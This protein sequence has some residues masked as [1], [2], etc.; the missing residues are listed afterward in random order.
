MNWVRV[1]GDERITYAAQVWSMY[2]TSYAAIGLIAS[3]PD[4]LLTEYD[5]W[6]LAFDEAGLS[7]AFRVAK[8]TPF[9][10]KIGLSGTDG[11]REAKT[12]LKSTLA[13]WFTEPGVYSEVSHK[14]EELARQNRAPAVCTS[15]A[16]RVLRKSI[17]P[18]DAVRYTRNIGP[19]GA[20]TKV[21]VGRPMDIPVVDLDSPS[22]PK[23]SLRLS[24]F[25]RAAASDDVDLLETLD[26]LAPW[27]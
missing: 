21:M 7:R 23:P 15:D 8:S 4:Q 27:L 12:F 25:E 20:V 16:A 11:S 3:G 19:V 17:E 10:L 9:G 24:G 14:M 26:S 18:V 5:V 6:W 13:D 22:C 1:E 2:E